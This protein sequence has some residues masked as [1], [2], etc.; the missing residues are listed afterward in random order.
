MPRFDSPAA[1]AALLG[2]ESNGA[3]RLAIADGRVLSRRYLPGTLILETTWRSPTGTAVVHDFM[4]VLHPPGDHCD[5]AGAAAAADVALDAP[6]PPDGHAPSG[7]PVAENSDLMRTVTCTRGRVVVEQELR[8]RFDYGSVVPWVHQQADAAGTEVFTAVG[9]PSALALHGPALHPHDSVHEGRHE[10]SAEAQARATWTLTWFPSWSTA[11]EPPD[12]DWARQR[13]HAAWSQWL[14]RSEVAGEWCEL[15]ER[16]LLTLRALTHR[17]TGG[18][19]A[20]PTTS[21]PEDF[22]GERN[23]DYRYCWLRDAAL[24][25]EALLTHGHTSAAAGWRDWL[26]RAIAGDPERLQIMYGVGGERIL[27][28]LEL[29]HLAGYDGSR[30]VRVGNAAVA[31][32]QGDVVG[33]VMIAL[34]H[35]RRAGL[36]ESQWSWALQCELLRYSAAHIDDPD[37]GLWEM[38]GEPAYFTHSRI[39][40]WAAFDC[41]IRAVEDEGLTAP[42][43]DV[44]GWRRMRARLREEVL[45]HGVDEDGAFTQT[46]GSAEVDASLL[47]IPHTGFV[48]ADDPRML[49]TVARIEADLL[50]ADGLV[51]RYRA[52]GQDGL[53]GI[54]HP[55]LVCCFWLVEQYADSGRRA[56]AHALMERVVA[57]GNDLGLFSE[58]YDGRAGRMAGNFPQAFSHLGLIRA[59]E[60]LGRVGAA[61]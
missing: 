21:L 5:A 51:L 12:P 8:V 34:A 56:D 41:G 31:Q 55:F 27:T 53:A 28:E 40:V 37:Q 15:V 32:Y 30:P 29:D 57:A 1:F 2:D 18:I 45:E 7:A 22:G 48:P 25:L 35:M 3:W 20:A 47:Q 38:R 39:M 60:A 9:G 33:E 49:A 58:E 59:A 16:S 42:A 19:V 4:P 10:L 61:D 17:T 6:V 52:Q 50:T 24:T 14:E 46:Y 26:L 43:A 54:E 23:W 36:A 13:T 44:E 11:P